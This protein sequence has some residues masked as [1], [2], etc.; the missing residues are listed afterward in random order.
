MTKILYILIASFLGGTL[1]NTTHAQALQEGNI[2]IDM[3]YGGPNFGKFFARLAEEN[4]NNISN[5]KGLG[6]AGIRLEYMIGDRIGIGTDIIY[7]SFSSNFSYDSLNNDGSLYKTYQASTIASRL[8]V[9]ARFNY[10]FDVSNPNLDAYL[11]VGAGTN[12]RFLTIESDDIGFNNDKVKFSGSLLP[13]SM[14][15]CTGI[16][17]YFTPNIGLNAEIGVGGPIVSG[18]L[19]IKI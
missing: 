16:R 12:T 17:Y 3:Y 14:R 2:V 11:G 10:H 9:H 4:G 1:C 15:L 8:R 18:G 7:N 13:I 5:I 6:P 19:S